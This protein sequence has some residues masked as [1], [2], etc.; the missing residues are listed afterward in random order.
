[1][2]K[3][4][5]L[6]LLLLIGL[7][8]GPYLAGKQG[9]VLISTTNYHIELSIPALVV[10]I[11]SILALLYLI[12]YLV[13]S[14]LGMSNSTF[15][16]FSSRKRKQAEKQ[17]L[18]GLIKFD[19]GDYNKAEKLL[20]KHAKHA[21]E[22]LLN[23]IKAA[24]AAQQKGDDLTANQHIIEAEKIAGKD[25]LML[26]LARTRILYKQN[27]LP[28]ARSAIDSLLVLAPNNRQVL[29]LAVDIYLQSKAFKHLDELFYRIEKRGDYT[30]AELEQLKHTIEDGLQDEQLNENG[31]DGLLNWWHDQS[32]QRQKDRYAQIGLIKRLISANDDEPAAE[33]IMTALKQADQDTDIVMILKHVTALQLDNYAKLIKLVE[34][35]SNSAKNDELKLAYAKALICLYTRTHQPDLAKKYADIIL[36][37][38]HL[39]Q[40]EDFTLVAH[41][42]DKLGEPLSAKQIREQSVSQLLRMPKEVTPELIENSSEAI[43]EDIKAI[44][45]Q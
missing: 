17:T 9:Y 3:L 35:Q 23:L 33:L 6:M 26:E 2:L 39:L 31:S 14:F 42:Y 30:H 37:H 10:I 28:A 29:H 45:K 40:S 22:P 5:F 8:A 34:K 13:S 43:Q 7:I 11:V 27:K 4:L 19:E 18:L 24:E 36:A 21:S 38:P 20:S 15:S 16:W 41:V 32:R 12:Q 44:N 25:N 1:M